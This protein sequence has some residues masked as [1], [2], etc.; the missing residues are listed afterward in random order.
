MSS[1]AAA[2]VAAVAAAA[3]TAALCTCLACSRLKAAA[4]AAAAAAKGKRPRLGCQGALREAAALLLIRDSSAA[5]D[6]LEE[7]LA[8]KKGVDR[9]E[10]KIAA[11][12]TVAAAITAA[13]A[14]AAAVAAAGPSSNSSNSSN[15][16]GRA[17]AEP[18]Q[19]QQQ[20]LLQG[21]PRGPLK[22][23]CESLSLKATSGPSLSRA[24]SISLLQPAHTETA[25]RSY[26]CCCCCCCCCTLEKAASAVLH[27]HAHTPLRAR[28][29]AAAAAAA[30]AGLQQRRQ[31]QQRCSS[32][33][34]AAAAAAGR[35]A[36][37][38]SWAARKRGGPLAGAPSYI[39]NRKR[40]HA[41]AEEAGVASSPS[42]LTCSSSSSS[43]SSLRDVLAVK[44]GPLGTAECIV[45]AAAVVTVTRVAVAAGTVGGGR[46]AAHGGREICAT[47]GADGGL[48]VFR[49]P[50][51]GEGENQ[52][53]GLL[54]LELYEDGRLL[55]GGLDG[56]LCLWPDLL[57]HRRGPLTPHLQQQ[58]QQQQRQQQ[59]Q[60]QQN[61][62]CRASTN[63]VRCVELSPGHRAG[64]SRVAVR[65]GF[66][67]SSG[68][69]GCLRLW[70]L[71]Q[72][73]QVAE[74]PAV[75]L[76]D[77]GALGAPAFSPSPLLQFVWL[78]AF[79][80]AG[81]KSGG[82]VFWD[83]NTG[84][85][86]SR[87]PAAH[88]GAVGDIQLLLPPQTS[89]SSS[90]GGFD[91]L[92]V[93]GG[94]GDGRLCVFDLRCLPNPVCTVQAS[95]AAINVVLPLGLNGGGPQGAPHT[96]TLCTLSA[97]GSCKAW[98]LR[99][100]S[101]RGPLGRGPPSQGAPAAAAKKALSCRAAA[102]LVHAASGQGEKALLCGACLDEQ[103]GLVCAGAADGAVY[104]F[105]M[106]KNISNSEGR[107][108]QR[109]LNPCWG[110]GCD[111]RGAVQALTVVWLPPPQ[112]NEDLLGGS[113]QQGGPP[114]GGGGP[115]MSAAVLAGGDDGQLTWLRF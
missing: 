90:S 40:Q 29:A 64:V 84:D 68:Y 4:A 30:A 22:P 56:K 103:E 48:R 46:C 34:G 14:A 82:I 110:F 10:A 35:D 74:L 9:I 83:L 23:Y 32:S 79:A 6:S 28:V 8:Q 100:C 7:A 39:G 72:S 112:A 50:R 78:N 104:L 13:A 18:L 57:R 94:R 26:N 59:Q 43:S 58:Q 76:G 91:P 70:E 31:Q 87:I 63:S 115:L 25:P 77:R 97:D 37:S 85:V 66:G 36:A 33:S 11:A 113:Q 67:V 54:L 102:G 21:P 88:R 99:G 47:G 106:K 86:V 107:Q 60:E 27:T 12:S 114:L 69:D 41:S 15:R 44:R 111:S 52:A 101:S 65:G 75:S 93:S 92:L 89:S 24:F 95:P 73:R 61:V 17:A 55:S 16:S 5:G 108:Q 105:D 53:V 96:P 80:A 49:L 109:H 19:E 71:N 45:A 3:A 42:R 98:D 38:P 20:P 2:A 62:V 51:E 81:S 1:G